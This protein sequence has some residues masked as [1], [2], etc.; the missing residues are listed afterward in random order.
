M[1]MTFLGDA[2]RYA[3]LTRATEERQATRVYDHGQFDREE[4]LTY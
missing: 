1:P 3:Q 2:N 4:V